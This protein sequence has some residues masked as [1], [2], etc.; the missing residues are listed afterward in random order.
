VLKSN[1]RRRQLYIAVTRVLL[2]HTCYSMCS[3][4]LNF[5]IPTILAKRKK[6]K[7]LREYLS[8]MSLSKL[9]SVCW[10][11]DDVPCHEVPGG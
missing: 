9:L 2:L 4:N 1:T 11:T 10:S 6:G 7:S 5:T 3:S 8:Q